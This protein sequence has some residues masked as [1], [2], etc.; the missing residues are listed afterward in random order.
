MRWTG[1]KEVV[2]QCCPPAIWSA[3][4]WLGG[5]APGPKKQ[6]SPRVITT[7]AELDRE[8]VRADHAAQTSDDAL[9]QALAE[10]RFAH[11]ITL[12]PDPESAAY[13]QA[14]M[15]LYR[16][17]SGRDSYSPAANEM[18]GL[19]LE[20]AITRPFPYVTRSSITVGNQLMM[21][22]FLIYA[23][24][25]RPGH[26]ILEFGPGYGKT[27]V[28][29]VQMGY[30]VTAVDIN[31]GFLQ[32]IRE[33]C[34]RLGLDVTVICSDMADFRSDSRFDRI[35]FYECFHHCSDHTRLVK[36]FDS[37]LAEGGKILFAAEPIE[38]DF[39]VPWGVRLDG[40]SVW[41]IRKFGW[42][43]LGFRTDYFTAL[44]ARHGWQ[45]ERRESH[46]V[47]GHKMFVARRSV[48]SVNPASKVLF[49]LQACVKQ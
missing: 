49:F 9:R 40:I 4:R 5:R 15:D 46:D 25:L 14:Q 37:L 43:E 33:R 27:T 41:S 21:I 1:F 44:M 2:K 6:S 29:L 19:D 3:M 7:L 13:R 35:I 23:A 12:P 32:A 47:P 18:T 31:P 36:N 24:E 39:P 38:D 34:R 30:P 26:R 48:T 16:L 28:E 11:E 10:F 45:L 22:G 17:I 8:I 42:L 20:A